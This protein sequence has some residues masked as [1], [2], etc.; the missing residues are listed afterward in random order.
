MKR[1]AK[2]G[3][4][5]SLAKKHTCY[6]L[7]TCDEPSSNG[8]MA[9]EMSYEGDATLAAYLLQGAQAFMDEQ[10]PEIELK[11]PSHPKIHHL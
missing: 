4:K 10:D 1:N 9:V 3:L 5:Q 8:E 11:N 2:K 7:I 6:V